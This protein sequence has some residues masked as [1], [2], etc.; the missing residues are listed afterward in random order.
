M[1]GVGHGFGTIFILQFGLGDSDLG[2]GL[3]L[4]AL[5]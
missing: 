4:D 1:A 5:F 2:R 3:D